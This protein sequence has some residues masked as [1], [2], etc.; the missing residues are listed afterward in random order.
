MQLTGIHHLFL[1]YATRFLLPN[2]EFP[3]KTP[4][5][6][7]RFLR[8]TH[9][10]PYCTLFFPW[11][12]L[13]KYAGPGK[14]PIP[15]QTGSLSPL[16][17]RWRT[18]PP[19]L[20]PP[21]I[22][23]QGSNGHS[24]DVPIESPRS[25]PAA[26]PAHS[27]MTSMDLSRRQMPPSWVTPPPLP[28]SVSKSAGPYQSQPRG[29]NRRSSPSRLSA[30]PS[31]RT[32]RNT[33]NTQLHTHLLVMTPNDD[34]ASSLR[35]HATCPHRKARLKSPLAQFLKLLPCFPRGAFAFLPAMRLHLRSASC[36]RP[37]SPPHSRGFLSLPPLLPAH[38]QL[39]LSPPLPPQS[40]PRF[41]QH[42]RQTASL[43]PHV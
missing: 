38:S 31:S 37:A 34:V 10:F 17:K 2:C 23:T 12:S 43:G 41:S 42:L 30:L 6:S 3:S 9:L 7:G 11:R 40:S 35:R 39:P 4:T 14:N 33:R 15:A 32:T 22:L 26:E 36:H 28:L 25:G 24:A 5:P 18:L 21:T 19:V 27:P 29:V 8:G 16:G 1:Y 13:Q 20:P